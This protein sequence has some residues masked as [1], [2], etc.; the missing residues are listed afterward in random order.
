MDN[1][2]LDFKKNSNKQF[3]KSKEDANEILPYKILCISGKLGVGK[4]YLTLTNILPF[5]SGHRRGEKVLLFALADHFKI[6][7]VAKDKFSY[8]SIFINKT[9]ESRKML[10]QRGTEEGRNIYGDDIWIDTVFT[11]MKLHHERSQITYF[12]IID[13]RFPNEIERF[14]DKGAKS[15]RIIS[16]IRNEKKLQEESKGD[17]KVYNSIK[18]HMSE[19]ALD[20]YNNFDFIYNND[21]E[22][23]SL[24]FYEIL[25]KL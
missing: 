25:N 10:Q 20:N 21:Q 1:Q 15:L 5:L 12:I 18:N 24:D 14:K 17:I 11:W 3:L 23:I 7:C 16:P 4:D 6:D 2:F 9:P 8:E 22:G 13:N 19:T